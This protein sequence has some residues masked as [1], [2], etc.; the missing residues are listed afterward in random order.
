LYVIC[1]KIASK[2]VSE[3]DKRQKCKVNGFISIRGDT[4][5]IC[6]ICTEEGWYS[7]PGMG[8]TNHHINEKTGAVRK[9]KK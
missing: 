4:K 5:F 9:P 6:S 1:L 8:G 3:I 2:L 7:T